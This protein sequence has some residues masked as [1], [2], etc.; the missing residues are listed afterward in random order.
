[1]CI[2]PVSID[3][4][5]RTVSDEQTGV[6]ESTDYY[7]DMVDFDKSRPATAEHSRCSSSLIL[8]RPTS[9][10]ARSL[11][12]T[13]VR[14]K[15]EKH[16][17]M[18]DTSNNLE[19]AAD[20]LDDNKSND[21]YGGSVVTNDASKAVVYIPAVQ[22]KP[23]DAANVAMEMLDHNHEVIAES[24]QQDE[25]I[26][27]DA[28]ATSSVNVK[29]ITGKDEA[30]K[31]IVVENKVEEKTDDSVNTDGSKS[32]EG[33]GKESIQDFKKTKSQPVPK[34]GKDASERKTVGQLVPPGRLQPSKTIVNKR[35]PHANAANKDNR[36]EHSSKAVL[37]RTMVEGDGLLYAVSEQASKID[38]VS[39]DGREAVEHHIAEH[40]VAGEDNK[41][42]SCY[43]IYYLNGFRC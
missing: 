6:N 35:E 8:S 26:D 42:I 15:Y 16:D 28:F 21:D 39:N 32:R 31:Q 9:A 5:T 43:V 34:T 24:I 17:I 33:T 20:K 10:S 12:E 14:H 29:T 27:T 1:M 7:S 2:S 4:D 18:V 23:E 41:G 30:V 36:I 37:D 25:F 11:S 40:T 3:E 38:T 22:S 19:N 13:Q